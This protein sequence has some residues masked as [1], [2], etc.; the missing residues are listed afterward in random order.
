[1]HGIVQTKQVRKDNMQVLGPTAQ[2]ASGQMIRGKV[3]LDPSVLAVGS[4]ETRTSHCLLE[5]L[6]GYCGA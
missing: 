5:V 1:M 2:G 4:W 6:L 3:L